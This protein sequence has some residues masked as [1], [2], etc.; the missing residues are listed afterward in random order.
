MRPNLAL[1]GCRLPDT[2]QHRWGFPCYVRFPLH[3]CQRQYPGGIPQM[4]SLVS[5]TGRRPSPILR[6]VGFRVVLFEACSAF[7]RVPACMLAKSP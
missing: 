3:A 6:R 7:T 5:S 4:L 1:A 2:L